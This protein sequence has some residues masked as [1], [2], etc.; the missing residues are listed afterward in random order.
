MVAGV[1]A[2]CGHGFGYEGGRYS[3]SVCYEVLKF[4]VGEF[5]FFRD[6][7]ECENEMGGLVCCMAETCAGVGCDVE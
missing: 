1:L 6:S 5:D 4:D 7:K 3:Q 2:M